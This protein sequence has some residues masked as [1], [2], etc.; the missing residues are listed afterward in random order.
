MRRSAQLSIPHTPD[1]IAPH[2]AQ[3]TARRR[4]NGG[5]GWCRGST[6]DL[7]CCAPSTPA[8]CLQQLYR[9]VVCTFLRKG[10]ALELLAGRLVTDAMSHQSCQ[11]LLV[12]CVGKKAPLLRVEII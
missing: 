4:V 2:A 10:C 3:Q 8:P 7:A 9:G 11:M 6:V 5:E 12:E 1:C